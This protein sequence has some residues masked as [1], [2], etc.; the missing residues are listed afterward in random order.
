MVVRELSD[1]ET[2]E[3]ALIENLQRQDLSPLEEAGPT[4]G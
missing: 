3:L 2:L 1:Q 4:A